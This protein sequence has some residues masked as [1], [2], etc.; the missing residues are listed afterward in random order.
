M[1]LPR[2]TG[3][4][5]RTVSR[6]RRASI[7]PRKQHGNWSRIYQVNSNVSLVNSLCKAKANLRANS[8]VGQQATNKPRIF[9]SRV[10]LACWSL[11]ENQHKTWK[12]QQQQQQQKNNNKNSKIALFLT[13]INPHSFCTG[14]L[15]STGNDPRPQKWSFLS[16]YK[17]KRRYENLQIPP[18]FNLALNWPAHCCFQM[19]KSSS[20]VPSIPDWFLDQY[21]MARTALVWRYVSFFLP[22][23]PPLCNPFTRINR[24]NSVTVLLTRVP[25]NFC[26]CQQPRQH[27]SGFFFLPK[28][29]NKAPGLYRG[30]CAKTYMVQ[31]LTQIYLKEKPY[32]SK[33]WP[34]SDQEKN[35]HSLPFKKICTAQSIPCNERRILAS[36][37]DRSKFVRTCVNE[38]S[39][40]LPYSTEHACNDFL[41][42]LSVSPAVAWT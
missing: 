14:D 34:T 18:S 17:Q 35:L 36:Q 19:M 31:V 12:K 10:L 42:P 8:L 13:S 21:C 33:F 16:L 23:P 40:L 20:C 6:M 4:H 15:Y 30:N 37:F 28:T 29:R 22:P 24:S 7:W 39:V 1:F 3:P 27:W 41:L 11:R 25:T 38:V 32:L 26:Q 9:T 2:R 5:W